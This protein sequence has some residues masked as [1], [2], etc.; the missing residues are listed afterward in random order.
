M[1]LVDD[2]KKQQQVEGLHEKYKKLEVESIPH[3]PFAPTVM[4]DPEDEIIPE[5]M[6]E[7]QKL[8]LKTKQEEERKKREEELKREHESRKQA[9]EDSRRM[10]IEQ[11]RERAE[12]R[13]K[14]LVEHGDLIRAKTFVSR[15]E[16]NWRHYVILSCMGNR[17]K[18]LMECKDGGSD[19]TKWSAIHRKKDHESL[20]AHYSPAIV[21]EKERCHHKFIKELITEAEVESD[22]DDEDMSIDGPDAMKAERECEEDYEGK[23]APAQLT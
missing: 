5:G 14:D 7:R 18:L 21:G 3:I 11:R 13:A 22:L 19:D 15:N 8:K 2:L 6:T 16:S 23:C 9:E 1:D 17:R 10:E 20:L 12:Q 4:H